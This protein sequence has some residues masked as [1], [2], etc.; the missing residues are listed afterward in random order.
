MDRAQGQLIRQ[1]YGLW[2]QL[3]ARSLQA[4]LRSAPLDLRRRLEHACHR[5]QQRY[6]RR[7]KRWGR[8][9]QQVICLDG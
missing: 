9:A 7:Q 5:A 3:A 4:K 2:G 8:Q 6:C 1:A